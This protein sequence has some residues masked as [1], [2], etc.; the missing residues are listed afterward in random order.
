M[1]MENDF[2]EELN[3]TMRAAWVAF[4]PVREATDQL[5][6][7]NLLARVIYSTVPTLCYAAETW[8]DTVATSRK[9]FTEPLRD[10]F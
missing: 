1:N 9:L 10:V 6:D 5:A 7:Q 2:K 3:G 8:A 4:A